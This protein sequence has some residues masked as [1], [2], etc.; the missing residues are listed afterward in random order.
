MS[1]LDTFEVLPDKTDSDIHPLHVIEGKFTGVKY[2]FG[3]VW[4]PEENPEMLSFEYELLQ[5]SLPVAD[6]DKDE[7]TTYMG[8]VII[9]MLRKQ[10]GMKEEP[11][12]H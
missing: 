11:D 9:A 5:D 2:K 8:D 12:A 4:F 10:L 6:S 7:F 1:I 3:R